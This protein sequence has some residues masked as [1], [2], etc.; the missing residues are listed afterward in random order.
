METHIAQMETHIACRIASLA[1]EI[2]TLEKVI[3]A[4]Q[5]VGYDTRPFDSKL[6]RA[7]IHL[8][9]YTFLEEQIKGLIKCLAEK[10]IRV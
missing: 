6:N 10:G 4:I 5:E 9:D 2:L 3:D 7:K 1:K 8:V